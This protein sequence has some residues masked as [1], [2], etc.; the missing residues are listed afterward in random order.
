MPGHLEAAGDEP[1]GEDPGPAADVEADARPLA[2]QF[3]R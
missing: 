3:R 1:G 2:G